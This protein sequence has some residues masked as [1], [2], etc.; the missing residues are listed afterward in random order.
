MTELAKDNSEWEQLNKGNWRGLGLTDPIKNV[1]VRIA[2]II[3]DNPLT[4]I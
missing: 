4:I 2:H 1:E 3:L